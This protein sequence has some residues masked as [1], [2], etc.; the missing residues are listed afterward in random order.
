MGT[1]NIAVIK[2]D[3]IGP[4]VTS[5]A[6]DVLTK[7]GERFSHKFNFTESVCGGAAY[8]KYGEPLPQ[9]SLDICLKSDSVLLGAV[10]GPQYDSLPYEKRPERALLGVRKAMGLY[11]NLRPARLFPALEKVCPLKNPG[12][13]DLLVVRELIGG[14]YFGEKGMRRGKFGA[15]GYDVMA[16]GE[17]EVEASVRNRLLFA[18]IR[19]TVS[20]GIVWNDDLPRSTKKGGGIGLKSVKSTAEAH[21]GLLQCLVDGGRFIVRITVPL[22]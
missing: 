4:E 2:G 17:L 22:Q 3:G 9:E 20:G 6:M 18:E 1:Y 19:N 12:K 5:A 16:Y 21:D 11:A 13:I 7:V 8:D 14:I 10:G 15:E